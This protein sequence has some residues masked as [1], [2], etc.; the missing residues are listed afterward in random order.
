MVKL[1][2]YPVKEVTP[3]KTIPFLAA[4]TRVGQFFMAA[5]VVDLSRRF[6]CTHVHFQIQF[7]GVCK[8]CGSILSL[9]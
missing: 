4:N 8:C 5:A 3:L 1:S 6:F 9:I 7:E 2:S